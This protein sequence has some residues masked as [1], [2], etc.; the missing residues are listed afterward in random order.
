MCQAGCLAGNSL[1]QWVTLHKFRPAH[2][3]ACAGLVECPTTAGYPLHGEVRA[4]TLVRRRIRY[5]NDGTGTRTSVHTSSSRKPVTHL[6]VLRE[7]GKTRKPPPGQF[8]RGH[9]QCTHAADPG[10]LAPGFRK[11]P[12]WSSFGTA[13]RRGSSLSHWGYSLVPAVS[14]LTVGVSRR[15]RSVASVL[16]GRLT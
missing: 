6:P 9:R 10:Q 8:G 5:V 3:V 1:R 11:P 12:P 4:A 7:A 14:V 15:F 13:R 2:H 16:R